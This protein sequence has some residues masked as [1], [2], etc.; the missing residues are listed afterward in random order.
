MFFQQSCHFKIA[1][2]TN[3]GY[4]DNQR[5]DIL[6]YRGRQGEQVHGFFLFEVVLVQSVQKSWIDSSFVEINALLKE[7][8]LSTGG[9]RSFRICR[10]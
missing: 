10:R 8:T 9:T 2:G 3:S 5:C 6:K 7:R 1:L 4:F